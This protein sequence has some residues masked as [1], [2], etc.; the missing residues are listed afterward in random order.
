MLGLVVVYAI[1][2]LYTANGISK[3]V[4][5]PDGS[6]PFYTGVGI[7]CQRFGGVHSVQHL[8]GYMLVTCEN[9][10]EFKL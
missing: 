3:G 4:V 8:V 1:S 9:G 5:N 10:T 2:I 6:K 7:L